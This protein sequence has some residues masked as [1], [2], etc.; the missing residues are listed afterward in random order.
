MVD[1]PAVD[2]TA[3]SGNIGEFIPGHGAEK[4]KF[5][6]SSEFF[7][8]LIENDKELSKRIEKEFAKVIGKEISKAKGAH[9]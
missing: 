7:S 9:N 8:F 1:E 2:V 4:D 3:F 6:L 5:V